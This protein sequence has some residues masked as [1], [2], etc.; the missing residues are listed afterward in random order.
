MPLIIA[1]VIRVPI[2]KNTRPHHGET[3]DLWGKGHRNNLQSG[4]GMRW[5]LGSLLLQWNLS[6]TTTSV[7][8]FITCDLFSNVL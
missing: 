5:Y 6:V 7:I 3:D 8:E 4:Q 2:N 1:L